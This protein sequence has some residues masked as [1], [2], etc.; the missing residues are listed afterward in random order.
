MSESSVIPDLFF[1]DAIKKSGYTG[2]SIEESR[3]CLSELIIK[4]QSGCV[5]SHTEECFMS[6]MKVLKKD[7][8]PNFIGRQFLLEMFY[9][10]S[11]KKC[12]AFDI[13]DKYR[14]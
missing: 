6:E 7:R 1:E 13:I 8:T 5:N 2:L 14:K 4:A 12:R 3:L 11:N 10:H 9:M